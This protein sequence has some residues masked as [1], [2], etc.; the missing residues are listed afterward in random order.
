MGEMG[1][2]SLRAPVFSLIFLSLY[3]FLEY[4]GYFLWI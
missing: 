4:K 3:I 2:I 1:L